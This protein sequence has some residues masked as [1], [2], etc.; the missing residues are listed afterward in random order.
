MPI[1]FLTTV[2][3]ELTI[4]SVVAFAEV[5]NISLPVLLNV[6]DELSHVILG[7]NDPPATTESSSLP[8][9][10]PSVLFQDH[11]LK[12]EY[13]CKLPALSRPFHLISP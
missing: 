6:I 3:E 4:L 9:S 11:E 13:V 8:H 7:I 12:R 2:P 10:A 5:P 1:I